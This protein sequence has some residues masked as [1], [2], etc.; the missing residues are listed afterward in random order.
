MKL[1]YETDFVDFARNRSWQ[2]ARDTVNELTYE[3]LK[4]LESFI[5]EMVAAC[6]RFGEDELN[7]FLWFERDYIAELL[8]YEDFDALLDKHRED[9]DLYTD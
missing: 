8:G 5:E 6:E 4:E 1:Y 2:G 9:A 7:N 3:E